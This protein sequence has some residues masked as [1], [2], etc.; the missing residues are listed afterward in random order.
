MSGYV[1]RGPDD[2]PKIGRPARPDNPDACGTSLGIWQ[3]R[4]AGQKNCERC[5]EAENAQRRKAYRAQ[6]A[7]S[8]PELHECNEAA[9]DTPD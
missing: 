8:N 1:Y 3:H 6:M 5:R 7:N 2:K 4:R 9:R